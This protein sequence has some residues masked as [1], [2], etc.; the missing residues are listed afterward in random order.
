MCDPSSAHHEESPSLQRRFITDVKKFMGVLR[1]R[2][3]PFMETGHD[4]IYIDTNVVMVQYLT[5]SVFRIN[6]FVK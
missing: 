5:L 6:A 2:G 4:L 1:D 3:N